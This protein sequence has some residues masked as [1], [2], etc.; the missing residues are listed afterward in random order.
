[1]NYSHQEDPIKLSWPLRS[2]RN[3]WE[4]W[5]QGSNCVQVNSERDTSR[6]PITSWKWRKLEGIRHTN[7]CLTAF[8]GKWWL[9]QYIYFK[10]TLSHLIITRI[11]CL[12]SGTDSPTKT[13]NF[14]SDYATSH[15]LLQWASHLL[16]QKTGDSALSG[17]GFL[18]I[19]CEGGEKRYN[20]QNAIQKQWFCIFYTFV[21]YIWLCKYSYTL[22]SF[23][24]AIASLW[25]WTIFKHGH[26]Q[27]FHV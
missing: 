24:S 7:P 26:N 27:N 19:N 15:S 11:R 3:S 5:K 4:K 13:L 8:T 20:L 18:Q 23:L 10:G 16:T 2:L 25:N 17:K 14:L 6:R 22:R 12:C 9:F 21:L 1:M